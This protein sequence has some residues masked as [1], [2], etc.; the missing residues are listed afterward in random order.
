VSRVPIR[1]DISPLFRRVIGGLRPMMLGATRREWAGGEYIP[2]EG[3]FVLAANHLSFV[4]PLALGHFL[5]DHGRA[6][7]YL[8]KSSLLE[9][10]GL[11]AIIRGTGQIPVHRNTQ[12]AGDAFTAAV[13]AVRAGACVVVLPE[14]TL[15]RDPELWPMSAKSGAAR[16][17]LDTGC[18]LIPVALWGTQEVL[19]PYR[20]RVP[21]VLPRKTMRVLAGPPVDLS[22]LDAPYDGRILRIATD[23]LM[24]AITKQLEELRQE[25]APAQRIDF[26]GYDNRQQRDEEGT[27]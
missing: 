4:D 19:W 9:V 18:P 24:A 23:R 12:R 2:R 25:S 16:I 20:G 15:T 10:P 21:H 22:D 1:E 17:A 14:A 27:R 26:H 11:G 5:V 6:P 3:G 8:A 7:H 13:Q